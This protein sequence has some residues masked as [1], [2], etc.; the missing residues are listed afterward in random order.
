MKALA[1]YFS[2]GIE[3]NME[4]LIQ[5]NQS[6]DQDTNLGQSRRVTQSTMTFNT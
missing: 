4:S 2:G 1:Q 3:E 5:E 6:P